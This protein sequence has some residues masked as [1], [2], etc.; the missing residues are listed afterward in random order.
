MFHGAQ[1]FLLHRIINKMPPSFRRLVDNIEIITRPKVTRR[2]LSIPPESTQTNSTC[3][4]RLQM[5]L[6]VI[7]YLSHVTN[8]GHGPSAHFLERRSRAGLPGHHSGDVDPPAGVAALWRP[9]A[10]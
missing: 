5:H 3:M 7:L 10:T 6:C 9:D 2:V 4:R 8:L 1:E